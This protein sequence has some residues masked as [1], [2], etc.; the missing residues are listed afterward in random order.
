MGE[1]TDDKQMSNQELGYG[2]E[3]AGNNEENPE[4]GAEKELVDGTTESGEKVKG[5]YNE[6]D[7]FVIDTKSM[8][9][10]QWEAITQNAPKTA[11]DPTP[12]LEVDYQ[13]LNRAH[14]NDQDFGG[15][16]EGELYPDE[17]VHADNSSVYVTET[18]QAKQGYPN[19][20]EDLNSRLIESTEQTEDGNIRVIGKEAEVYTGTNRAV[21]DGI[22]D[23]S[24]K[25]ISRSIDDDIEEIMNGNLSLENLGEILGN[26]RKRIDN[27]LKSGSF[28][29]EDAQ[30]RVGRL[31]YA[32]L[33]KDI[34]SINEITPETQ[35]NL[36]QK[37][38]LLVE[39]GILKFG[40]VGVEG[41]ANTIC[42]KSYNSIVMG[43]TMKF[44]DGDLDNQQLFERT[45]LLIELIPSIAEATGM[46]EE[47]LSEKMRLNIAVGIN[48]FAQKGDPFTL[49]SLYSAYSVRKELNEETKK[50]LYLTYGH[51]F[52]EAAITLIHTGK[53]SQVLD[54]WNYVSRATALD[55][56]Q[57]KLFYEQFENQVWSRF[58]GLVRDE[59]FLAG[60]KREYNEYLNSK[61]YLNSLLG[62]DRARYLRRVINNM[63]EMGT[64]NY[65][66]GVDADRIGELPNKLA[67]LKKILSPESS[68]VED[69]KIE[70]VKKS[71]RIVSELKGNPGS[72]GEVLKYIDALYNHKII[73]D[74]DY[75]DLQDRIKEV[76]KQKDNK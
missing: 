8:P 68:L 4:N 58:H 53:V 72:K 71:R 34:D 31:I 63:I 20:A 28:L 67:L 50:E 21:I 22:H 66:I 39:K 30:Y 69:I 12:N 46:N 6:K 41:I 19:L 9:R 3:Q 54:L 43:V 26:N 62:I 15:N 35:G 33:K 52:R 42:Q 38:N 59:P 45:K 36:V 11:Y 55:D 44:E 2:S 51:S 10:E 73:S 48:L 14:V 29:E 25:E 56:E 64:Y 60:Y 75:N 76:E 5:Y 65:L 37:I 1:K 40:E 61:E 18:R 47:W 24:L 23:V 27:S 74:P 49:N 32:T 70:F 16:R 57:K 7:Q 17:S 13:T